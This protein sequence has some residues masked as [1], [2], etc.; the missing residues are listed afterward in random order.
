MSVT[1]STTC[2][3]YSNC[4][5]EESK[6][7]AV[8]DLNNALLN[9]WGIIRQD[10]KTFA[11][12]QYQKL[13]YEMKLKII[14][15]ELDLQTSDGYFARYNYCT[16]LQNVYGDSTYFGIYHFFVRKL[17]WLSKNC[18]E[19]DLKMDVVNSYF[20]RL[21]GLPGSNWNGRTHI[22][23]R[24]K[25]RW[26][27]ISETGGYY[28]LR[29]K[30]DFYSEGINCLKYRNPQADK[31]LIDNESSY[32]SDWYF[33]YKNNSALDSTAD[34]SKAVEC[35]LS[36]EYSQTLTATYIAQERNINNLLFRNY[37]T[38]EPSQ[39]WY[40]FVYLTYEDNGS[41]QFSFRHYENN[42]PILDGS[43]TLNN[44]TNYTIAIYYDD[45]NNFKIE[46]Y[47]RNGGL[48]ASY[49]WTSATYIYSEQWTA[50]RYFVGR[51]GESGE[52][53]FTLKWI[54]KNTSYNIIG[55]GHPTFV[56]TPF[57]AVDRTDAT[58]IKIIKLPY[59][60][61]EVGQYL[62]PNW[63]TGMLKIADVTN[64]FSRA[65]TCN[66]PESSHP[67]YPYKQDTLLVN[68]YNNQQLRNIKWETKLYHSDYHVTKFVYD[69]FFYDFKLETQD[70]EEATYATFT[71]FD[72]N[73]V[74]TS[75]INSRFMFK[76]FVSQ[77]MPTYSTDYE[78]I[79]IVARNNEM[80][81]FN[82]Q[83]INYLRTGYNYDVKSK[84]R[85]EA[86]TWAGVGLGIVGGAVA[87]ATAGSV[88]TPIGS[89]V[90]AVVGAVTGAITSIIGAI[91]TTAQAED[92]FARKQQEMKLQA[93]NVY[94]ADDVDLMAN[95]TN[96]R[97]KLV[98]YE[99]SEKMK[100]LLFNLF[101][102]YGYI[103]DE[104][105]NPVTSKMVNN[106]IWFN[107]LQCE[108]VFNQFP[109]S[110]EIEDAIKAKFKEGV[111]IFHK[112]SNNRYDFEQK[113]ENF[114]TSFN[115]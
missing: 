113:Y 88:A 44:T 36:S 69:S 114:E 67:F 57:N 40:H 18:I 3:L 64:A 62:T 43:I 2:R 51:R 49:N 22:L 82:Q 31:T 5:L 61:V 42:V 38:S 10:M 13:A 27:K 48:T 105:E 81:I 102:Y 23:R 109:T 101:F 7:F 94:G 1:T 30:I 85:T 76:F 39:Y 52:I 63:E 14:G 72:F 15:D 37:E 77:D 96:N 60:P 24:H 86:V 89:A 83:Y 74:M 28:Y 50:Y 26:E 70:N 93:T 53:Q 56:T 20:G 112:R 34:L 103:S 6:N 66:I 106:R 79:L 104:Y 65:V 11:N 4:V 98:K 107:F 73:F 110:Q 59:S 78:N 46:V 54:D 29:P 71:E 12:V 58:L 16:L 17:T 55:G 97:A 25:D 92:N 99:V 111:T 75:T 84:T 90:G 87:G 80:P 35:Y 19:L 41:A 33:V 8:E 32:N 108:A 47:N 21:F 91:N 68:T 45:N 115:Q 9:N 95:Y 100:N